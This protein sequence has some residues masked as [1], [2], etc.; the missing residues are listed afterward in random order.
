MRYYILILKA[1]HLG[2]I[3]RLRQVLYGIGI[4]RKNILGLIGSLALLEFNYLIL[5]PISMSFSGCIRITLDSSSEVAA[6]IMPSDIV[7]FMGFGLR[8]TN[9]IQVLF[10][11]W[12][13]E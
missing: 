5:L 2:H 1:K 8:L 13:L 4:I 11:S 7:P 10:F 9:R 3:G 6:R 12:S